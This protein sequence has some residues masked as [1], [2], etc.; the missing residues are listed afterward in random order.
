LG[1]SQTTVKPSYNITEMVK[2]A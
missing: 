2:S 1:N